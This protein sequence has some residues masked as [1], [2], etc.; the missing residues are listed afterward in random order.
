MKRLLSVH[1]PP[2]EWRASQHPPT[3]RSQGTTEGDNP[4]RWLSRGW[5]PVY[6]ALHGQAWAIPQMPGS[7]PPPL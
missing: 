5:V 6:G 4:A 7:Q 1:R 2:T 3:P